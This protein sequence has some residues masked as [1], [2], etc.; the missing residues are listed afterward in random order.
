MSR[1]DTS[2]DLTDD[3]LA[4]TDT[5]MRIGARL[6]SFAGY[7][8]DPAHSGSQ[9][10][11]VIVHRLSRRR[12]TTQSVPDLRIGSIVRLRI[13]ML[14]WRH[15]Q[16]RWIGDGTARCDFLLPLLPS[17]LRAALERFRKGRDL[18][19][20]RQGPTALPA[21]CRNAVARLRSPR[22]V[23]PSRADIV[24]NSS[25]ILLDALMCLFAGL[26]WPPARRPLATI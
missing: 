24:E 22:W 10:V 16:V 18:P 20:P 4:G 13:P 3:D 7:A 25:R 9:T 17:E 5:R 19:P 26:A 8:D 21:A 12:V 1:D 14:G 15:L 2:T 6:Q 11:P 23:R